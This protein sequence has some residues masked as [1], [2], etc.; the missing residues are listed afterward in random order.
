MKINGNN[1]RD[2]QDGAF[3]KAQDLFK[4][5]LISDARYLNI[6]CP[7]LLAVSYTKKR[8]PYTSSLLEDS[9]LRE[10]FLMLN[11]SIL[12]IFENEKIKILTSEKKSITFNKELEDKIVSILKSFSLYGGELDE[13]GNQIIDLKSPKIGPHYGVNLLLGN[14]KKYAN[15]LLTTPKSVVDEFGHGSFRGEA[16]YQILATRWD[17]L[18]SENG[19]PFNRQF[20]ILEDGKE[21]FYSALV[22]E[23]TSEAKCIHS[24]NKTT[25]KYLSHELEIIRNIFILPQEKGLPSACECQTIEIKNLS[26]KKRNLSL[27]VTNMFGLSNPDCAKVDIIYQTVI[28]ETRI[29]KNE[30]NKV[31]AVVPNYY[32]KYFKDNIRFMTLKDDKGFFDSFTQDAIEFIG[33]GDI[34]HPTGFNNFSNSLRYSGSSF[35]A[36]KK[37]F[38][39]NKNEAKNFDEFVGATNIEKKLDIYQ[40]LNDE[41]NK[42]LTKFSKHTK[43]IDEL[44]RIDSDYSNYKKYL[45][46]KTG[47]NFFDNYVNNTLPFQVLYQTF[48]SRSFAQTQKGYREI[49][50]REIQD[51]Y[52]SMYY[53]VSIGESKLVKSL[54]TKWIEN[55]YLMGYA[56]HNFYYV[57]KEP[58]MCSDDQI[59]LIEAVYRFITLTGDKEFLNE[60]FIIAGSHKKRKLIDTLKSIITYSAKISIGKHKLPLLDSADWNDCLKID[61]DYLDGPRKE[62]VYKKYLKTTHKLYGS[63]LDSTYSESIMNAFLLI[64]AL[65][66]M[67]ELVSDNAYSSELD[68]LIDEK[69][70]SLNNYAYINDYF[71]RVLINKKTEN[72]NKY[73]GSKGDGLSIDPQVDGS[74][75]LNSFS[76]SLLSDVASEK[77]IK[78]MLETVDKVLKTEAG[79][80]LCSKHDL[81][82][83]GSKGA[84]TDHYFLG[85]RENGGVFKHATMMMAVAM[86]R[87]AKTIQDQSLKEKLIDDSFYMIDRVLPYKTLENPYVL[88]GNPRFCTQYNNSITNENIGP[89]L[90]GTATWLTLAIYEIVGIK[91]NKDYISFTPVLNKEMGHFE[92]KINLEKTTLNIVINKNK[93]YY[94]SYNKMV[95]TLDGKVNNNQ[96]PKFEDGKVH[97]I[98]IN[99]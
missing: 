76:W 42:L 92:A 25:I 10:F 78:D 63:P 14:R 90:S 72:N 19:N 53:F 12:V 55:V 30:N 31:C 8:L 4:E 38:I 71:V 3:K 21:I 85:D 61:A 11:D 70:T 20:Y 66:D 52:A 43:V 17:I 27:V 80:M 97:S 82:R 91:F 5:Y 56:N 29:L 34:S 41:F 94:P 81:S 96:I 74:Y 9:N 45:S 58:G 77:Q 98:I 83:A 95:I 60:K 7:F 16:A 79:Y 22:D 75:Y 67:K 86:L 48:V 44:N 99:F 37:D 93:G 49:G 24:P 50:F 13:N 69:V 40:K 36:L 47:D 18:P 28:T 26:S 87:K 84:S 1:A 46:I 6:N 88:K 2:Y 32:P 89:I 57:G 15:P 59:W 68:S 62:K 39:L 73:I 23:N 64:I 65:K 35:L 54:L 33:G 51:I